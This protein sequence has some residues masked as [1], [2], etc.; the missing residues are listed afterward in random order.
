VLDPQ[1]LVILRQRYDLEAATMEERYSDYRVVDGL[2][3]AFR[4]EVRRNGVPLIERTLRSIEFNV[5]LD[6]A[7]FTKPS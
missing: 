5:L 4:A 1:T 7:L 3:V 6:P 2:Q